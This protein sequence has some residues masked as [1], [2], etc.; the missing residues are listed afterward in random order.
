MTGRYRRVGSGGHEPA[1]WATDGGGYE[2][3]SRRTWVPSARL[4]TV[5]AVLDAGSAARAAVGGMEQQPDK[6][7]CDG[8]QG[9]VYFGLVGHLPNC[10]VKQAWLDV[11]PDCPDCGGGE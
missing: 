9:T 4:L 2:H 1:S 10:P 8:C 5:L 6:E 7:L 3:R 11:R